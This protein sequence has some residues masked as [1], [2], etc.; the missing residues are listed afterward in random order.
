MDHIVPLLTCM[1]LSCPL[2]H[3]CM[4][5][6]VDLIISICLHSC[7]LSSL[8]GILLLF[9]ALLLLYICVFVNAGSKPNLLSQNVP[10]PRIYIG[11]RMFLL[12]GTCRIS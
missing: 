1:F 11:V 12:L 2:F 6:L 9:S 4:L 10:S 8:V 5:M 3:V 7:R